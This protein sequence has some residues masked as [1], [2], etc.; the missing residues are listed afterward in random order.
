MYPTMHMAEGGMI[1]GTY[2]PGGVIAPQP[3]LVSTLPVT[4]GGYLAQ[5]H[6]GHSMIITPGLNGRA[7][8]VQHVPGHISN[9]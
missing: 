8:T 5:Q 6:H 2:H 3:G 7:P 1:P 4:Q 9:M